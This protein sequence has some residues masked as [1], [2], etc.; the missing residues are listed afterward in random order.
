MIRTFLDADIEDII[1]LREVCD[2]TRPWNNPEIDIFRKAARKDDLFL[3]AIKD[4][5][6]IA[7][8]MGGYDGHRG[9]GSTIWLFIHTISVMALLQR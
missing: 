9:C 8:L 2:L 6:P 5:Q 4:E 1:S 3:V 7:T